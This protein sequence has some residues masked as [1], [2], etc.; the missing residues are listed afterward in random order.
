MLRADVAGRD[1]P[2]CIKQVM[3]DLSSRQALN[4]INFDFLF[5]TLQNVS[6]LRAVTATLFYLLGT[7]SRSRTKSMCLV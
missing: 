6:L 7:D 4:V 5:P 1:E 3:A 2:S